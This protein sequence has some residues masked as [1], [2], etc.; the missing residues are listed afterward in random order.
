M[1]TNQL[2]SFIAVAESG[3]FTHAAAQLHLTQPAISKRVQLLEAFLGNRL[4]DRIGKRV[5]LTEAGRVL[6]PYARRI[7]QEIEDTR[8]AVQN[9][10]ELVSGTLT[11]ASSHHIGLHRLPPVLKEYAHQFPQ[12]DMDISF[13]DSE[14]VYE[15]VAQGGIELGVVTLAT[16]GVVD[17]IYSH[18]LWQDELFVMSSTD[19]AL[20]QHSQIGLQ[21]LL[22]YPAILPGENTFTRQ[23]IEDHFQSAGLRLEAAMSTNYLETIKM[24]V[25][26]GMAW[27]ILPMTM[28]DDTLK[29]LPIK[30]LRLSRQ[31]GYIYHRA[32]TLS[33]A[34]SAFMQLLHRYSGS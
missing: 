7:L 31:L 12:V 6:L 23:L 34:A 5:F 15:Q 30:H 20:A 33:N 16:G 18:K 14:K 8:T 4:F 2:V 3:S 27:S 13:L 1:D 25:S 32:H 19:H 17:R 10:S 21:D 28:C 24:M 22:E 11:M 29:V 26:V 9:L